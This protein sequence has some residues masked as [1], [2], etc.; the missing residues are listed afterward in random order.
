[1]SDFHPESWNPMWSV[2]T[3]LTGLYSFML[4]NQPTLGSMEATPAQRR[5]LASQSLAFNCNDAKFRNLFTDLVE[6][7]QEKL[8]QAAKEEAEEELRRAKATEDATFN[9]TSTSPNDT[10]DG[11]LRH[12]HKNGS[13]LNGKNGT[14]LCTDRLSDTNFSNTAENGE[15]ADGNVFTFIACVGATVAIAILIVY[16]HFSVSSSS[17]PSSSPD[18]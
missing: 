13:L 2:S 18:L 3:I 16:S 17:S 7:H 11:N 6:F 14:A 9:G 10:A 12:Q 15:N 8:R 1:M 4:E 5:K